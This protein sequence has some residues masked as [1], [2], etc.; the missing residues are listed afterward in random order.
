M[1]GEKD[2][3]T[4]TRGTFYNMHESA[5]GRKKRKPAERLKEQLKVEPGP[6]SATGADT[7]QELR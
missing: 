2:S 6:I 1:R 4:N 7:S 3:K 5:R